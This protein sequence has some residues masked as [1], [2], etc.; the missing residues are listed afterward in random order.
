MEDEL[1]LE[2]YP[3]FAT[4]ISP[5]ALA[6]ANVGDTRIHAPPLTALIPEADHWLGRSLLS[7]Q[8]DVVT[9][10]D[11]AALH[12][13]DKYAQSTVEAFV[14]CVLRHAMLQAQ[15]VACTAMGLSIG[16]D[17]VGAVPERGW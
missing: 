8:C 3:C 11:R 13:G 17:A 7:P 9:F 6:A 2:N 14:H 10:A 5:V 16:K 15:Y 1:D 4:D 12:V